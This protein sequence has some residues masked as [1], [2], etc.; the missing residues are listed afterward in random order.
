MHWEKLGKASEQIQI[1]CLGKGETI[2]TA[3]S[4]NIQLL[5][6]CLVLLEGS[7][8]RLHHTPPVLVQTGD[9]RCSFHKVASS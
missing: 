9:P 2:I 8:A 5:F 4:S 3:L 6:D 7:T 1:Q